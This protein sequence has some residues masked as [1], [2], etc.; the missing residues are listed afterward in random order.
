MSK[1]T[2][3]KQREYVSRC[4]CMCQLVHLVPSLLVTDSWLC[5]A[6]LLSPRMFRVQSQGPMGRPKITTGLDKVRREIDIMSALWHPNVVVLEQIIDDPD[7]DPLIL[8]LEY[9]AHGQIMAFDSKAM[10]YKRNAFANAVMPAA[11][12]PVAATAAE[13]DAPLPEH[14]LRKLLADVLNGL[15]YR[16]CTQ[17][18]QPGG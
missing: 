4:D 5:I 6:A 17:R 14:I 11:E 7:E 15:E 13:H 8:V 10:K 16:T 3:T 1:R 9:A 12:A 18:D 2:L